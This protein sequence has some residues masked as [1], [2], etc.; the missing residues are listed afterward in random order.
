M[1]LLPPH[2]KTLLNTFSQSDTKSLFQYGPLTSC[3]CSFKLSQLAYKNIRQAYVKH[4]TKPKNGKKT[5]NILMSRGG[6]STNV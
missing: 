2:S 1:D 6:S 4:L 3:M 5:F